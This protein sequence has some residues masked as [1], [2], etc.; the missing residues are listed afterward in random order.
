MVIT[1]GYAQSDEQTLVKLEDQR[2]KAIIGRDSVT[3]SA[4]YNDSYKGILTTGSNLTKKGVMEFQLASNPYV[5]MSIEGVEATVYG[6]VGITTAG[7]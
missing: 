4:L 1:S 6:N 7:K 5:K 2:L 3:L